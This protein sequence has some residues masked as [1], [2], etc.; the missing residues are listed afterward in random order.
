MGKN[1]AMR[2][3]PLVLVTCVA[4]SLT[5]ALAFPARAGD[6]AEPSNSVPS[7]STAAKEGPAPPAKPIDHI[8]DMPY[9]ARLAL[10][11]A[12]DESVQGNLEG[13]IEELRD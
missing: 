2:F 5:L 4:V 13:A 9:R 8:E 10:M 11:R 6:A 12:Q 1:T 7:R 3:L